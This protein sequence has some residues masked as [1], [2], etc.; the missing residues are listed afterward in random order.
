MAK[1]EKYCAEGV[2]D[3]AAYAQAV[4]VTGA[5]TIL[6]LAGQVAYGADGSAKH[7]GDFRAQAREALRCLKALVEKGGGSVDSIVKIN[8]YVTDMRYRPD[9]GAVREEFFG[10][11][12]KSPASTLVGVTELAH[13]DWMI[14]VECIAIV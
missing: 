8:A 6:F 1:L 12:A 2:Y 13:P 14:E 11:G 7:A 9:W 10:K 4:K 3:P 5:Q